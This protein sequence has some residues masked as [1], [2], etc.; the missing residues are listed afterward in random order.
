MPMDSY[1]F[2]AF[3]TSSFVAIGDLPQ[4]PEAKASEETKNVLAILIQSKATCRKSPI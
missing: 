3:V 1:Y 2:T 4:I